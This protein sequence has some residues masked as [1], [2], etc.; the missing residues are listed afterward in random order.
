[1]FDL[2]KKSNII[3]RCELHGSGSF[4][5]R[6]NDQQI[7]LTDFMRWTVLE[8]RKLSW[9][10]ICTIF[11]KKLFHILHNTWK[12]TGKVSSMKVQIVGH[13]DFLALKFTPIYTY[14]VSLKHWEYKNILTHSVQSYI[15]SQPYIWNWLCLLP[16]LTNGWVCT[17]HSA[18]H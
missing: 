13:W 6:L 3:Y 18:A 16:Q 1:M 10:K 12:N 9:H 2:N 14:I 17:A 5:L 7:L 15:K 8:A 11:S 4:N